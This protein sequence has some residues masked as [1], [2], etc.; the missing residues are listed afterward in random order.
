MTEKFNLKWSDYQ[1]NWDR[2][3]TELRNYS[4]LSDVTLI[5]E[6]KLKFSAH[7]VILSSCSNMFKF[8]LKG[9][10]Q[11]SQLLYL[12]GVSSV[13]LGLILDY[14]YHGEV[15][16]FQ[17][18]LDSFLETASKLELEGMLGYNAEQNNDEN[19]HSIFNP[20]SELVDQVEE[21][22]MVNLDQTNTKIRH[23]S[24]ASAN[25]TFNNETKI[26]VTSM[27]PEEIEQKTRELYE[28]M[29][30]IWSCLECGYSTS[31]GGSSTIRKHVE[32][33]IQGLS[34]TCALCS[35]E[36][37]TRNALYKHRGNVH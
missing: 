28:R 25:I 19:G 35:K 20:K 5:S 27:T 13:N 18:Q 14:I 12:G 30:G 9:N 34:Y 16:L 6:D 22:I 32:T 17:E 2:S 10:N 36:F 15:N 37:G 3:L 7:K 29:E 24:R 21:R 4:D 11:S 26:N 33:H 23:H 1:S 31:S 8:I